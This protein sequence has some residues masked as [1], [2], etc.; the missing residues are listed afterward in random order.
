MD[1]KELERLAASG[2]ELL[3][4]LNNAQTMY[5]LELRALYFIYKNNG[6]TKD[7]AKAEKHELTEKYKKFSM[8]EQLFKNEIKVYNEV[9]KLVAPTAKID[10]LPET[11]LRQLLKKV[12]DTITG[13]K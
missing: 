11:E 6:I 13:M 12:I 5:F 7:N 9:N 4:G 2:A 8:L 1:L 3:K 10:T